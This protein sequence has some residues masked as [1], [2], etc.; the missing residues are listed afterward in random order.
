MNLFLSAVSLVGL[1][2]AMPVN[3]DTAYVF[4]G[5]RPTPAECFY[6][7]PERQGVYFEATDACLVLDEREPIACYCATS[8]GPD[9][10]LPGDY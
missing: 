8:D 6:S 7:C 1:F 4:I 5:C 2:G 10:G 9:S 3:A